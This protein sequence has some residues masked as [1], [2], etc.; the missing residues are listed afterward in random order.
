MPAAACIISPGVV[1]AC[2]NST[3]EPRGVDP[4]LP[5][6]L[7]STLSGRSLVLRIPF[8]ALGTSEVGFTI[9]SLDR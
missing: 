4:R 8:L 2:T 9:W 6:P 3:S 1:V 7:T 5:P